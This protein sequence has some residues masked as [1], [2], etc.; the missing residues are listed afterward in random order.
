MEATKLELA[1]AIA[2]ARRRM[3]VLSGEFNLTQPDL[4]R[5][6]E[7]CDRLLSQIGLARIIEASLI[8]QQIAGGENHA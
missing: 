5:L 8:R 1:E 7:D 2:Q 6:Y 4:D 3:G